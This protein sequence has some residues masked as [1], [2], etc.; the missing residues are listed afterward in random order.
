M[1]LYNRILQNNCAS[2]HGQGKREAGDLRVDGLDH[3]LKGRGEWLLALV[4]G[5]SG[6]SEMIKRCLFPRSDK[7]HYAS[8][9]KK[10]QLSPEELTLLS[11]WIDQGGAGGQARR[12][13]E[14]NA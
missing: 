7:L 14:T 9:R 10:T 11:W 12:G 8:K 4:G 2:C 6:E 13:I 5:K 1:T 3:L